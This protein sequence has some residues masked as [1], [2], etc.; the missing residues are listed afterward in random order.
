MST[1]CEPSARPLLT[2]AMSRAA[3]YLI[4]FQVTLELTYRCNLRCKHC[5]I[6]GAAEDELS[7]TE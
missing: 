2:W 1:V 7:N 3:K 6:D 5:Y 4:P